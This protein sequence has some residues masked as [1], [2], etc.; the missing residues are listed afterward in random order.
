[1]IGAMLPAQSSTFAAPVDAIYYFILW[2]SVISFVGT[3]GL[4]GYFIWRYRRRTPNDQTPYIEGHTATEVGVSVVLFVLVMIMFV[5]GYIQYDH[6]RTMPN[7]AITLNVMARQWNWDLTYP[8]GRTVNSK[9]DAFVVPRG[10]K[11]KLVMTSKDV[12]HSFYIP[13]FRIKQDVVPNMYTTLWFEAT[14]LGDHP[15]FCAEYCGTDHSGMLG[16]IRV[17]EPAAYAQWLHDWE[18]SRAAELI[19]AAA[20]KP[21]VKPAVAP[22]PQAPAN[23]QVAQGKAL[24]AARAC[25]SCHS[26]DG[27]AGIGPSMANLFGHDVPLADGST[28][29]AD[30]NYLQESLT[31]PAAKLVKGFSP[32]MPS[33]QGQLTSEEITSLIAYIKSLTQ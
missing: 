22:A 18:L 1:M 33:F 8:N 4:L 5:W 15:L 6:Q 16:T 30:E 32:I 2:V 26:I 11:V 17:V 28:V 20:G 27:A 29:K 13:D 7:D 25:T 19:A 21:A 12:L 14:E 31:N 23:P 9:S 24:F 3:V 10:Q